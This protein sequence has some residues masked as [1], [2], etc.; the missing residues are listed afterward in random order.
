MQAFSPSTTATHL[1]VTSIVCKKEA[2]DLGM[3][4]KIPRLAA[5]IPLHVRN[6][7]FFGYQKVGCKSYGS[8]HAM[9]NGEP[10]SLTS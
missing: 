7:D 10:D 9:G 5:R 2:F 1:N 8:H 4:N 6:D 3:K